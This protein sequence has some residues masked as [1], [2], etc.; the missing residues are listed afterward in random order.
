[1]DVVRN[2]LVTRHH[3]LD[4]RMTA[5]KNAQR[6]IVR[7]A[8]ARITLAHRDFGER[9]KNVHDRNRA[10]HRMQPRHFLSRPDA[11]SVE[12]LALAL[13]DAFAR[14]EHALLVL[15]ERRRDEA[16]SV[17]DR[18]TS[19]K[20]GGNQMKIRLRDLDVVAE[21]LVEADLERLDARALPL[22]RLNARDRV[23]S[24]VA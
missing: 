13:L 2:E 19:L 4:H 8:R 16:L 18:L 11:E 15:L 1:M 6:E 20:V 9:R 7:D 23:A 22:V 12:E 3:A 10:R 14:R 17:R 5:R 24:A 21:H